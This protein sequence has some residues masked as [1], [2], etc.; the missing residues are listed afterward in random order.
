MADPINIR[1]ARKAR[2]QRTGWTEYELAAFDK[3][4]RLFYPVPDAVVVPLDRKQD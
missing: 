1:D 2:E 3:A 4:M